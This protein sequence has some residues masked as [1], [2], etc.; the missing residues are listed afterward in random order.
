MSTKVQFTPVSFSDPL[1]NY[2]IQYVVREEQP[3]V[4]YIYTQGF[5]RRMVLYQDVLIHCVLGQ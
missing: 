2:L 4:L 5:Y 1:R 3:F